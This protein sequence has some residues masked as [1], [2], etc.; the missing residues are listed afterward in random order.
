MHEINLSDTNKVMFFFYQ[1]WSILH[2]SI[3][4]CLSNKISI[5]KNVKCIVCN[6]VSLKLLFE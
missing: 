6:S 3:I 5:I 2:D 1:D 4:K